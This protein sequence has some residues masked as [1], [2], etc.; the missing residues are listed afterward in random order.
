MAFAA[1]KTLERIEIH[2]S[3]Q[4]I[5]D[6]AFADCKSLR[7]IKVSNS[8]F[9]GKDP[10]LNCVS[11]VH[12]PKIKQDARGCGGRATNKGYRGRGGFIKKYNSES[13]DSDS[14]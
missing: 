6:C 14:E 7:V 5:N 1:C 4:R 2:P 13:S 8:V 10:F 9:Y 12:M 3:V 11:L